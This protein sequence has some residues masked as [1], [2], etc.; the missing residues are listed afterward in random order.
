[1]AW[2]LII[3]WTVLAIEETTYVYIHVCYDE[4]LFV[5]LS[6]EL[7]RMHGMNDVDMVAYVIINEMWSQ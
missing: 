2:E 7:I 3:L 6:V 4:I 1:M 5:I